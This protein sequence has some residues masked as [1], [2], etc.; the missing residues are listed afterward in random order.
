MTSIDY[1]T[2]A[3]YYI[4]SMV[5]GV[6]LRTLHEPQKHFLY[7]TVKLA[8]FGQKVAEVLKLDISCALGYIN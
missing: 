7:D 6:T 1:N 8:F 3:P 5:Q 2:E 4:N